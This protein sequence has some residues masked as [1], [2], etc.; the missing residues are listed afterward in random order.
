MPKRS[1]NLRAYANT[2][3][4]ASRSVLCTRVARTKAEHILLRSSEAMLVLAKPHGLAN[5]HTEK[6][7]FTCKATKKA[8]G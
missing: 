6:H 7:F 5:V 3:K 1:R 2:V 8:P 4:L